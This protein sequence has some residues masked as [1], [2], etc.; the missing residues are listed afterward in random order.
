MNDLVFY[1]NRR[2]VIE[3]C[4]DGTADLAGRPA[5]GLIG[6]KYFTVLPR[7]TTKSDKDA[8]AE[9]F[10]KKRPLVLK[11]YRFACLYSY[12]TADIRISPVR[13]GS[14]S[15]RQVKVTLRPRVTCSVAKELNQT[16]RLVNIGK[17][18][19]TLAH[20]VR[21]PLNAIKGAVVYLRG[22]Y[23]DEQPLQEFTKIMEDEIA[24]LEQYIVRFLSSSVTLADQSLTDINSLIAKINVLISLQAYTRGIRVVH[25]PGDIPLLIVN[26]F[27]MEQAILNVVNNAIEAMQSGGL[28]RIRTYGEERN[29]HP[30][31]VVEISDTGPGIGSNTLEELRTGS[32]DGKGFG[33]LIAHEM[34]KHYNG[35]LEISSIKD[36]GTSVRFCL[37][38]PAPS[39][40]V[41]P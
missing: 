24:R 3:S 22:K 14:G 9:V 4:S 16:Q 41:Q 39:P 28:L 26:T 18:A 7:I 23:A 5:D 17:I 6:K 27:H 30:Y 19:S 34:V 20:G 38:A 15:L 11:G 31:I 40:A 25:E 12:G 21:N 37:P 29:D 36:E 8:V 35:H 13:D 2:L 1:A 32:S 10:R 33:L